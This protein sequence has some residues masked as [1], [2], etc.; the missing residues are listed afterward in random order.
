[1]CISLVKHSAKSRP[2]HFYVFVQHLFNTKLFTELD[3]PQFVAAQPIHASAERGDWQVVV[4]D[5]QSGCQTWQISPTK[6]HFDGDLQIREETRTS[7]K[8]GK[9]SNQFSCYLLQRHM[10]EC[11]GVER[12]DFKKKWSDGTSSKTFYLLAFPP[13]PIE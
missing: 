12:M 4:V 11:S 8:E 2:L 13:S 6:S 10:R 3:S 1:M 9:M 7:Q 5:D